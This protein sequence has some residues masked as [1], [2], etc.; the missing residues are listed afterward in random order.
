[1]KHR[2]LTEKLDISSNY[3]L[4]HGI[5]CLLYCWLLVALSFYRRNN[6]FWLRLFQKIIQLVEDIPLNSVSFFHA[7]SMGFPKGFPEGEQGH[8]LIAA[9]RAPVLSLCDRLL[10]CD[11]LSTLSAWGTIDNDSS[12]NKGLKLSLRSTFKCHYSCNDFRRKCA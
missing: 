5:H 4:P 10:R 1:M 8:A 3:A 11:T 9:S 6:F 2:F 12:H 7:F